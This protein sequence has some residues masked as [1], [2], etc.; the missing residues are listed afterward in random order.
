MYNNFMVNVKKTSAAGLFYPGEKNEIINMFN[1]FGNYNANYSSRAIIVPHAGYIYSGKL[2]YKGFSF[3]DK[4][5]KNIFIFAPAH[6]ERVYGC[7]VCDYD[8]F[9]TPLG[10]IQVNKELSQEI[11]NF[12]DCQIHNFAFEKEHSIEVQLPIIK[13]LFPEAKI[14]PVLYGC[15]NFKNLA[16]TISHFWDNKENGFVISSDLSHFYPEKEAFK[17]DIYTAKMIEN[18]ETRDFEMEQACGAV[19]ICGLVNFAKDKGFSLIR[20]GMR[21]SAASTG[22]SSRVVGYGSWFLY[23]GTKNEYIK[24]Y[25]SDFVIKIC[26]DSILS[27]LQLGSYDYDN[28]PCVF[29]ENGASFVTLKLNGQLRG[30]IGSIVAHR[31]LIKDLIQNAHS[32]AFSDP[33]FA[34]L[35]IDEYQNIEISVSL[36]S[37]PERIHFDDEE[38]LLNQIV[39]F[40]DG[41]IIRDGNYQA[42]FLP[43]VW[44]E[45]P[46][47]H[48]FLKELKLKAGMPLEH[49]S[50]TFEAF[51]F[52]AT[53]I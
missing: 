8:E 7:V 49:F 22:D 37:K 18:N 21:N 29:E 43:V 25:Y 2:A 31:S 41:L 36:L 33:R 51:K 38:D 19:G 16:E 9:E 10:N 34:P 27:G 15:E 12:C 28:Y 30:C 1:D 26:K 47:K 11:A 20:A 35:T 48:E 45:L 42:V 5:V 44:E 50:E 17:I 39:P 4:N 53:K 14:I 32:A 3:L 46:D 13:N 6:Y 23:E 24:T 40:K 52:T